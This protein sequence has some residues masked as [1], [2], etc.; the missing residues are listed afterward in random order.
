MPEHYRLLVE[1]LPVVRQKCC[2]EIDDD[3]D[4]GEHNHAVVMD[5][6]GIKQPVHRA[7]NDRKRAEKQHARGD[8]AP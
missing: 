7:C 6:G 4:D 8:Q 2:E 1:R 3:S 5:R